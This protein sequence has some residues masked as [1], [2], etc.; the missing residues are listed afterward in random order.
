VAP[1]AFAVLPS[2]RSAGEL[3]SRVLSGVEIIGILVGLLFLVI[4][5]AGGEQRRLR[6]FDLIVV[7]LLTIAM[8][9]SRFLVSPRLHA[10]REQF[11]DQLAA[12]P[13]DDATRSTFDLLH[14]CSVGLLAFGLFSAL[15]LLGVL[16]GRD[17]SK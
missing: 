10:I 13:P 9:L 8:G 5:L 14:R 4:A 11:G 16:I 15:V 17:S 6:A 3:V 12:L 1:S 7:V 2:T